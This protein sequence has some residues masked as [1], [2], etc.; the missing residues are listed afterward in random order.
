M[1]AL[2]QTI[3]LEEIPNVDFISI[4]TEPGLPGSL[5]VGKTV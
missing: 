3:G 1:I 4:T 5:V 2:L